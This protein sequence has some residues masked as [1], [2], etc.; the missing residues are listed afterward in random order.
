MA[1][2]IYD[3]SLG[4]IPILGFLIGAVMRFVLGL[5]FL[6]ATIYGA[7]KGATGEMARIPYLG[8]AVA[9]VPF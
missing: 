6:A 9:K 4:R 3:A 8:D 2:A 1:L 7:V 5:G